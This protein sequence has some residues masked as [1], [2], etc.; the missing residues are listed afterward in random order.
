MEQEVGDNV[1]LQMFSMS[2]ILVHHW[3]IELVEMLP[4]CFNFSNSNSSTK[5]INNQYKMLRLKPTQLHTARAKNIIIISL[6]DRKVMVKKI[7]KQLIDMPFTENHN[8]TPDA[9]TVCSKK[10]V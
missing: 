7:C 6:S 5:T 10:C 1:W 9:I 2:S 4:D 8:R 3:K